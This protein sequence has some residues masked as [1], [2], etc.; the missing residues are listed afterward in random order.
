MPLV[1]RQSRT[2]PTQLKLTFTI[3]RTLGR[4]AA[5]SPGIRYSSPLRSLLGHVATCFLLITVGIAIQSGQAYADGELQLRDI[6]RVKGL[7][8]NTLQGLG[9]VVGLKG[10]G[11]AKMKPTARAL[12]RTMQLLGSNISTDAQ[13][14]PVL[15][16]IADANNTALVIVT[17]EIPPAGAQQG[18]TLDCTI[19]ALSAKSLE[20]GTLMLT[21]LLGPRADRPTVY[22]LAQGQ[23]KVTNP[24]LPT[25]AT[26]QRGCKMEA[27]LNNEFVSDNK[28]TLIID[29]D[30]SD[31]TTAQSIE[32]EINN[33][34]RS[35]ISGPGTG[36]GGADQTMIAQAIDPRHVEVTIPKYYRDAPVK[37]M[38]LVMGVPL[39]Y[40]QNKKRVFINEREGVV[41]IG[42]DVLISP[43][44]INHKN[45]SIEARGGL[46]GFVGLDT[47]N[48]VQ[49]RAKL[50]NLT[51]ALN[52][53]KVPT[54]DVIAIIQ[55]LKHQGV[56][57]GE[58][59][60]Q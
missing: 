36:S 35:G 31:F 40:L 14:F 50:A 17:A 44:A 48:P 41:V 51:E 42:E 10:T 60:I 33:L 15:D 12:A 1:P 21:P 20:G 45:L 9:L 39:R 24:N 23:L 30:V 56:L 22:A 46:G 26:V 59:V 6:C 13:G 27:T 3:A 16:E 18:D 57:Y 19:S 37:F 25:A 34:N 29:A 55:A 2:M 54:A 52:R 11:D 38:S 4:P 43:V 49:P 53:L 28:I 5:P 32:D 7:E 58:L 47:D 8:E